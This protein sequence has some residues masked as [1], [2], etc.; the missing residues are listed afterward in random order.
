MLKI[1]IDKLVTCHITD[2]YSCFRHPPSAQPPLPHNRLQ[3]WSSRRRFKKVSVRDFLYID[4]GLGFVGNIVPS[5]VLHFVY[6]CRSCAVYMLKENGRLWPDCERKQFAAGNR[7][8]PP[9]GRNIEG[10]GAKH[11]ISVHKIHSNLYSKI[12]AECYV[13]WFD[14]LDDSTSKSLE[15][16]LKQNRDLFV[17]LDM[18]EVTEIWI[19]QVGFNQQ[20]N[21]SCPDRGVV[22]GVLEC[23]WPSFYRP[24]LAHKLLQAVKTSW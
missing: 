20:E 24:C 2:L 22:R 21:I 17:S 9:F 12:A 5:N 19:D 6:T 1:I 16:S 23:L 11:D 7:W 18:V 13:R 15:I 3:I 10:L 4:T 14:E 8:S